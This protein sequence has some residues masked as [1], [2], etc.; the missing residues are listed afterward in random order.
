[1]GLRYVMSSSAQVDFENPVENHLP[2]FSTHVHINVYRVCVCA[3]VCEGEGETLAL[4]VP[5]LGGRLVLANSVWSYLLCF[6]FLASW[7]HKQAFVAKRWLVSLQTSPCSCSPLLAV[8]ERVCVCAS[9][10]GYM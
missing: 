10:S 9:V 2:V 6:M 8:S 3:C 1:M 4:A 7:G 5:V